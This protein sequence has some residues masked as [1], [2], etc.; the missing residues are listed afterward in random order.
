M[1]CLI[2]VFG[3]YLTNSTLIQYKSGTIIKQLKVINTGSN[4]LNLVL[5]IPQELNQTNFIY[6]RPCNY[7]NY[8]QMDLMHARIASNVSK[9]LTQ[10]T[11]TCKIF[12]RLK[13]IHNQLRL[14]YEDKISESLGAI[15]LLTHENKQ[16]RSIFSAIR[17][18]FNI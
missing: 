7:V 6:F 17:Y 11:Q 8:I 10:F 13:R 16:K 9:I 12:T 2:M 4:T 5:H 14:S 1:K 18:V 15:N 3:L